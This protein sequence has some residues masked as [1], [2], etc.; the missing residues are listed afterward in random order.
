MGELDWFIQ[1][2]VSQLFEGEDRERAAELLKRYQGD[3]PGGR[4][5]VQQA[6]LKLTDRGDLEDLARHVDRALLDYRD[7]LYAAEY[8]NRE[9]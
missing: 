2:R 7:V 3:S 8:R 6:I 4:K 1:R 9:D 5:R